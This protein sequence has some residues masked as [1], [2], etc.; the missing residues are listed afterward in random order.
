MFGRCRERERAIGKKYMRGGK[1][2]F[3]AVVGRDNPK[4][5]HPLFSKKERVLADAKGGRH[6]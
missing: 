1:T 4:K 6:R 5:K 2:S 3:L